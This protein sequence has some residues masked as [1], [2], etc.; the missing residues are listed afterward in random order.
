MQQSLK[1]LATTD[2]FLG[3]L[4]EAVFWGWVAL[5]VGI[6]GLMVS[7]LFALMHL[8]DQLSLKRGQRNPSGYRAPKWGPLSQS[9]GE[10]FADPVHNAPLSPD[11]AAEYVI[12]RLEV[13]RDVTQS[14]IRYF[15]YAPLLFGLMGTILAL[16]ALLVVSGETLQQIQPQLAGVF[17][18]TLGGIV[19][20]VVA[21]VGGLILD[22]TAFSTIN[23]AQDFIHRHI[24]PTLPER[25]IAV[26]IEDAVL[27]L[28]AER[29]RAVAESFGSAMQPVAMRMGQVA[30]RC[31]KAAEEAT[32]AFSEAV[33]ALHEA[34]D[35]GDASRNFKA[36][37]H[38]IDSS[39]EQ[40]S[41]ATKQ[42]AEVILRAGELRASYAELLDSIKGAAETLSAA[43]T[44]IGGEL[45]SQLTEFR[46]H[47]GRM[48]ASVELLQ[49]VINALSADL[50]HRA[51]ADSAHL[52]A[53]KGHVGAT[54][55][56]L[57]AVGDI[58]KESSSTLKELPVRVEALG[59]AIVEGVTTGIDDL[60]GQVSTKVDAV[61]LQLERSAEALSE[62][63]GK[64]RPRTDTA[65][66]F[67]SVELA[68][69]IHEAAS[70]MKRASE[71]YR[72]LTEAVQSLHSSVVG[73]A[74]NKKGDG[75]FRR[76]WS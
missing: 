60:V 17:A 76:L 56:T 73:A 41:D 8:R 18:G 3:A 25:R 36:G 31:A 23:R 7:I 2:F 28:I 30:E 10:F 37:A 20:S 19:G 67:N 49:S 16:R 66:A 5:W 40:L 45:A 51:A 58:A 69:S 63:A 42:T 48:Q 64:L 32:K 27:A 21:A 15:A 62:A 65:N 4:P 61:S 1:G 13:H 75:F 29:A 53:I 14:V 57:A 33:R 6:A 12:G 55:R 39:A 50:A 52:E 26:R 11:A 68:N 38:M 43:N 24:L 72:R 70:E 46:A 44:R 35:L 74:R 71:E 59:E 22:A 34:G 9:L 54:D 47:G